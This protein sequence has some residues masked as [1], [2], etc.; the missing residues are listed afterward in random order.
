MAGTM[1]ANN[2][3]HKLKALGVEVLHVGD[4]V[5][6][7]R[8]CIEARFSGKGVAKAVNLLLMAASDNALTRKELHD[9]FAATAK[10]NVDRLIDHLIERRFLVYV[11]QSQQPSHDDENSLDIF[12]WH[13]GRSTREV[14]KQLKE[15][16]P[17]ILGVNLI[18]ARLVEVLSATG[19]GPCQ[20]IDHPGL[21]NERQY[22]EVQDHINKYGTILKTWRLEEWAKRDN[23]QG[24]DCVVATSDFGSQEVLCEWNAF[25]VQQSK[26]FLPVVLKNFIGYLGPFV[27]P[28]TTACFECLRARQNSH[29]QHRE[30]SRMVEAASQKA[31]LVIGFHPSMA[32]VLGEITAFELT[33]VY[34]EVLPHSKVGQLVELNLLSCQMESHTVLKVPRCSVCSPMKANPP[35]AI[36]KTVINRNHGSQDD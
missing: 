31:Q 22:R 3:R 13:F 15:V 12:Y 6:L 27:L 18:S 32:S 21:R 7:K 34:S 11:D 5:I 8:G 4:D 2:R 19:F 30:A 17:T 10:S 23:R 16:H 25:C 29:L 26:P 28:G 33:K 35:V 20:V 24:S 9:L 36:T 14:S 1:L